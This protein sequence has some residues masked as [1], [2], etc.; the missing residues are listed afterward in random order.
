MNYYNALVCLWV[1]GVVRQEALASGAH[2]TRI[3]QR[4]GYHYID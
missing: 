3:P 4:R 1:W 2:M